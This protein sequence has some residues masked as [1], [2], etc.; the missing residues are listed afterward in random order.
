MKKVI[1]L[2]RSGR[3]ESG[4]KVRQPLSTLYY[5]LENDK[6]A[7][8]IERHDKIIKDELNVKT[9]IRIN[10]VFNFVEMFSFCVGNKKLILNIFF[11]ILWNLYFVTVEGPPYKIIPFIPL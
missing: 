10:K 1:E 11:G 5:A 8:F 4:I 7:S 9:I 3:N 6:I 2:G